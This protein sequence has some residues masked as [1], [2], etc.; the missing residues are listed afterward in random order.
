MKKII[1][2]KEIKIIQAMKKLALTGLRCLIV[3]DKNKKL[4]GTLSDGDIR[5]GILNGKKINE[6][7]DSIYNKKPDYLIKNNYSLASAKNLL[8]SKNHLLLPIVNNKLKII[9]YLNWE[10]MFGKEKINQNLS[11]ISVVIMAGGKGSRLKPFTEILPK[12]LIPIGDKPV[13]DHIIEKFQLFGVKSFFVST[14]YKSRILKSYLNETKK[15][16]TISFLNEEKPLGTVG[17]LALHRKKFNST[18]FI[19]NCDII[20]NA[21]FNEMYKFHKKSKNDIT[22]VVSTKSNEIPYGVCE[23][24]EKGRFSNIHEKPKNFYLANTGLYII[25]P[26]ILK[27]IP[28]NKFFHMTDLIKILKKSRKKIGV[29][30]IDESLWL[31][32]GQWPEYNKN[33]KKI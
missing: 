23:L 8:T 30:P 24:D 25:N 27:F 10:K 1:I 19:T 9:D 13:I 15:N 11:N 14:I 29:F 32:I 33:S 16:Y 3:V 21:D 17:G 7:I 2:S 18:I 6:T 26:S 31:D 28:N 12:P 5:R 4:L 22:M 20:I